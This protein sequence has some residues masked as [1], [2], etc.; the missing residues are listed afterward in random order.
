MTREI[1]TTDGAPSPS[2]SYSQAIVAGGLMFTAGFGP[3]DPRT[4]KVVGATIEEQ[5]HQLMQ[6][7]GAVLEAR[8]LAFTDVVKVTV[9]LQNLQRDFAGFDAVYRTYTT[10]P[11]PVRTTVG[12]TL[13]GILI[14]IDLVADCTRAGAR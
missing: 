10:A 8:G 13:N 4:N 9:H 3:Q 7:L 11:F 6:N 12:S 14:E 5:T 1:V 2:W